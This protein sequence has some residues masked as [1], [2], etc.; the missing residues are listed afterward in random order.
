[1]TRLNSFAR[2][3]LF[4]LAL[5]IF[6]WAA[7]RSVATAVTVNEAITY[8]HYASKP[9][10]EILS[11]PYNPANQILHTLLCRL[12]FRFF[13]VKEWSLR[14][15]ALLGLLVYFWAAFRL[16]RCVCKGSASALIASAV[17]IA[18]PFSV[19]WLPVS[20]GCW[21]GAG[22]FLLALQKLL[23]NLWLR[24]AESPPG[25]GAA[26]L[27]FGFSA[28]FHISFVLP[29]LATLF[30]V[31]HFNFWGVRQLA[32]WTAV[33]RLILP[34]G[35]L[36]FA[37][38]AIPLLNLRASFQTDSLF[39]VLIPGLI[40][41]SL[42]GLVKRPEVWHVSALLAVVLVLLPC[43]PGVKNFMIVPNLFHAGPEAGMPKVAM[44]LREDLRRN[45][46]HA[47]Q[48]K[49][50]DRLIEP[51]NFYRRRYALGAVQPLQTGSPAENAEYLILLPEDR[52]IR[53]NSGHVKIFEN[54][55]I[56]LLKKEGH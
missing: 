54:R 25:V 4:A 43:V 55:G 37:L 24:P 16:C 56:S 39:V 29:I 6:I 47:V 30:I 28:G 38:W 50:S 35:L 21:M 9:V 2:R 10:S 40:V 49:A 34:C 7:Y 45:K 23:V 48:V 46:M 14:L 15:P 17:F 33:N 27:L 5:V 20:T 22:F 31:L 13:R 51:I 12:F 8:N 53:P 36:F 18:S 3:V 41:L 42:P 19:G 26:S 11:A 1:M 52:R 44:A 32:F